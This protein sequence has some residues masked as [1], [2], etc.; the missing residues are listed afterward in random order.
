MPEP[1]DVVLEALWDKLSQEWGDDRRHDAFVAYCAETGQ[2]P[3][4]GR[5]YR[6]VAEAA[7]EE[8]AE[9]AASED[10]REDAK[11]RITALMAAA[12]A[13][14]NAERDLDPP[15]DG[16]AITKR[17]TLGFFAVVVLVLVYLVFQL[18]Q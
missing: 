5:R 17:I 9:E 7:P 1:P 16:K 10:R 15:L 8:D 12:I 14:L 18:I 6:L 3:E 11:R 2:L 4:A 13:T